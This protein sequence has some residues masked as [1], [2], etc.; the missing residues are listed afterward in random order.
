[1]PP[2]QIILPSLPST[3]SLLWHGNP[4]VQHAFIWLHPQPMGDWPIPFKASQVFIAYPALDSLELLPPHLPLL[5]FWQAGLFGCASPARSHKGVECFSYLRA[6]NGEML[7]PDASQP[8]MFR[9]FFLGHAF[10]VIS[11]AACFCIFLLKAPW[12][13]KTRA[14]F[15]ERRSCPIINA[16]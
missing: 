9:S 15:F 11:V 3:P 10:K 12:N 5:T 13:I 7:V 8:E 6:I 14:V 4:R 16:A 2:P 1:M